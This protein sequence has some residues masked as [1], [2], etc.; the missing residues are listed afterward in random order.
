MTFL[1][2]PSENILRQTYVKCPKADRELGLYMKKKLVYHI[3]ALEKVGFFNEQRQCSE[4]GLADKMTV[5]EIRLK[6]CY[7]NRDTNNDSHNML[8]MITEIRHFTW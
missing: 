3:L 4:F 2:E 6:F 1:V 8:L 7:V 5:E